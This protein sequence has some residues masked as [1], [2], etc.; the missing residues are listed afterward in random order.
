MSEEAEKGPG[1]LDAYQEMISRIEQSA[2]RMRGLAALTVAV[3]ALLSVA[4]LLQLALPLTGTTSE[5]VSLTDPALIAAEVLV[6]A[7]TLLWL[8]VG[9][10]D[11]RFT[12]R[13]RG[14]I[15][16]A[17]AKERHLQDQMS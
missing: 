11:L 10:S 16:A 3:A 2:G 13:V 8:Y 15:A 14:E 9:V 7:L 17:R 1:I 6:L 4:Y 5:T 12:T